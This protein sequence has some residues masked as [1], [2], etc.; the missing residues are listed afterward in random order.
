M[1]L[2]LVKMI[3][4]KCARTANSRRAV[5]HA[6]RTTVR[7]NDD[8]LERFFRA[9]AAP[10][11]PS[12]VRTFDDKFAMV[13]F[14]LAP[15]AAFLIFLRAAVRCFS[16]AI[17]FFLPSSEIPVP[18]HSPFEYLSSSRSSASLSLISSAGGCI[19]D[20]IASLLK[21]FS[22]QSTCVFS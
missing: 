20:S 3:A 10:F 18:V 1:P 13:L 8:Y 19:A 9:A 6:V 12:A 21:V 2:A 22:F 17:F 4:E 16:V 15:A 11:L 5:L 7:I 14:F